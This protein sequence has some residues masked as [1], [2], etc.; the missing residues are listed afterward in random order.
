MANELTKVTDQNGVDHP[1]KDVAAFPRSEQAVLGAKNL[2][3][4]N[5]EN[6]GSQQAGIP[7]PTIVR[8]NDGNILYVEFSGTSNAGE[9]ILFQ[10]S[11]RL[12]ASSMTKLPVGRFTFSIGNS[13]PNI[14]LQTGRNSAD[15]SGNFISLALSD[16]GVSEV[17]FDNDQA[18]GNTIQLI[19][20]GNTTLTN[21]RVYPMVRLA[22]DPD[23]TY[24]PN[25]MTNK[26]LT[27]NKWDKSMVLASGDLDDYK[28]AG[29][30]YWSTTAPSHSPEN[31]TYCKMIVFVGA[32]SIHQVVLRGNGYIAMRQFD[33]SEWKAWYKV[34]T[35]VIS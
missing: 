25:A 27:E 8:D 18:Y 12:N 16:W 10:F 6:N 23:P 20:K 17:T 11:Q 32:G 22:T 15:M 2:L 13:D 1:F 21:F 30:F 4:P 19:V 35:T 33:G 31:L 5:Y 3:L 28:T 26:E 34:T 9:N 24:Q 14:R 29:L 7:A